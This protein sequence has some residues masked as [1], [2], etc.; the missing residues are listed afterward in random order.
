MIRRHLVFFPA[1]PS[2]SYVGTLRKTQ[3]LPAKHGMNSTDRLLLFGSKAK[4]F[5]ANNHANSSL[6]NN[7]ILSF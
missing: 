3:L 2:D 6:K 1:E 4:L 7:H 5:K